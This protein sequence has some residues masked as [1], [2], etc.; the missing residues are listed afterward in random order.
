MIIS[1][2]TESIFDVIIIIY[3]K[4]LRLGK[5]GEKIQSNYFFQ[6]AS[7]IEPGQAE[8]QVT[9]PAITCS[10]NAFKIQK[11]CSS[12]FQWPAAVPA[13]GP[14]TPRVSYSYPELTQTGT[15]SRLIPSNWM[16]FNHIVSPTS[17]LKLIF[18]PLFLTCLPSLIKEMC[19]VWKQTKNNWICC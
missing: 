14:S 1:E 4:Q 11:R 15:S 7:W 10:T 19:H 13:P 17:I 12:P 8:C 2:S 9:E 6:A 3:Q 5:H 18:F 16:S